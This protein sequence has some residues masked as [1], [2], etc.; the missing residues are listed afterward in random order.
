MSQVIMRRLPLITFLVL[1]AFA[2]WGQGTVI[3]ANR[4][5]GGTTHVWYGCV[6]CV[7]CSGHTG[8]STN[9]IPA[10]TDSYYCFV[11][12]GAP[13]ML[14]VA[15]TFA[16]LLGAL[17]SNASEYSLVPSA[18]APTTFRTITAALGNISPT[19]AIFTNIPADAPLATFQMVVWDN[20]SGLYPT[21]T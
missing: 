6:P 12:T 8:N 18:T 4:F 14:S 11:L 10:G 21:W 1:F 20:S 16:Q 7:P 9:D 15:T 17:G 2:A 3:F 13:G 19:T 5:A